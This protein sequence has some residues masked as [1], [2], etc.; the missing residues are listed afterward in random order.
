MIAIT[1]SCAI[2]HTNTKHRLFTV[3]TDYAI[4]RFTY[5]LHLSNDFFKISLYGFNKVLKSV[6]P[7]YCSTLSH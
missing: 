1:I 5:S 7:L 2:T 6:T 4:I 3:S